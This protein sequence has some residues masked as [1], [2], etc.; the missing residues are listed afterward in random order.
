MQLI[1]WN[2]CSQAL[3]YDWGQFLL[4]KNQNRIFETIADLKV[5]RNTNV[6]SIGVIPE[7]TSDITYVYS[8]GVPRRDFE[9]S[10]VSSVGPFN[11]GSSPC[12]V[13]EQLA[14]AAHC[15]AGSADAFKDS[16]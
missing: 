1:G 2:K 15:E 10:N 14:S 5:K 9:G 4:Y 12:H 11:Y 8:P 3:D 13:Y 16:I 7:L 6:Q